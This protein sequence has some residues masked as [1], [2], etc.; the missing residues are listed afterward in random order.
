MLEIGLIKS[1]S[2]SNKFVQNFE[3][4]YKKNRKKRTEEGNYNFIFLGIEPGNI[5]KLISQ[6]FTLFIL[7]EKILN[8]NCKKK[9][10]EI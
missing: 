6:N 9:T 3:I 5:S 10:L 1:V 8:I 4:T 7:I 2:F